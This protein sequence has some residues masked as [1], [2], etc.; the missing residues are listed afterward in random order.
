MQR[1]RHRLDMVGGQG[2]GRTKDGHNAW[3]DEVAQLLAG[4]E[5]VVLRILGHVQPVDPGPGQDRPIIVH[6]IDAPLES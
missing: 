4:F 5:T 3:C 2:G 6:Q 1:L